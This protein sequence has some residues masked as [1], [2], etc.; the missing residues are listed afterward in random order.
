M[1]AFIY[2]DNNATTALDPKVLEA[3]MPY[4]KDAYGNASS[5]LN[6][7]GRS[8]A[9]AVDRARNQVAKLIGASEV[10]TLIFTS[11]ATEAINLALKGVFHRYQSKGT[12]FITC[13]TEHKAVLE[14][15]HALEKLGA[16][17]TYLPVNHKG[18]LDLEELSAAIRP[19]TVM[20]AI[21]ASNNE[22]GV[23]HPIDEIAQIAKKHEVLFFCDATQSIGK[24]DIDLSKT[25]IDLLCLSAHK[26]HGPKGIGG[27]Y[28]RN[29][30]KKIQLE[31]LIHGG[32]QEF[33]LR[34][35]TMNVPAI[36]GFGMAAELALA[37]RETN[38]T[39]MCSLRD[40]L[41]KLLLEIPLSQI[42]GAAANRL[43][44]VT[45]ITFRHVQAAALLTKMPSIALSTGAAC[46][47]GTR[48]PSHVLLAMGMK[49]EDCF[50]SIR[51]SL[52]KW[53]TL[54]E[55]EQVAGT[56]TEVIAHLRAESPIWE[57]YKQG[58]IE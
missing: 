20:I 11:G 34:G 6:T 14:T 54:E 55:I 37:Q 25:P 44:H 8:A 28:V 15:F 26:F 9:Q 3:M 7:L 36:V 10:D 13:L 1:G 12:H 56:I 47:S 40:H 52:S 16:S 22:T 18:Q 33:G 24:D 2:L 50:A 49:P 17:V 32:K 31:P 45:N 43:A 51:I 57:L 42:N 30:R 41:E 29:E 23:C 21:M 19:D 48:D 53:T 39:T 46:V 35:G 5:A 4:F 58:L 38:H 27:L